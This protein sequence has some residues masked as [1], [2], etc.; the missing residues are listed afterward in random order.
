MESFHS[1]LGP[2]LVAIFQNITVLFHTYS[3]RLVS[4]TMGIKMVVPQ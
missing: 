1:L 3:I 2:S 4:S